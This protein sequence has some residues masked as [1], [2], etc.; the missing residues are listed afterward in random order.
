MI[1]TVKFFNTQKGL[2][3]HFAGGRSKDVFVH[4]SA[5]EAA[6]M[7]SLAKANACHLTQLDAKGAKAGGL[8]SAAPGQQRR[9]LS[10]VTPETNAGDQRRLSA[11]PSI[12]FPR[13]SRSQNSDSAAGS[14]KALPRT[15]AGGRRVQ[16]S[17]LEGE[18][19]TRSL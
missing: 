2:W 11:F 18:A 19:Y 5:V 14:V 6:G 4:A 13:K 15:G 16:N 3:F 7:R 1:G 8:K 12:Q 17:H 10:R 9:R